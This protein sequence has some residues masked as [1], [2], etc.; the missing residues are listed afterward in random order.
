MALWKSHEKWAERFLEW[1]DLDHSVEDLEALIN[2]P[3]EKDFTLPDHDFNRRTWRDPGNKNAIYDAFGEKGLLAMDLH[4]CLDFLKEKT[5]P[6]KIKSKWKALNAYV[7]DENLP[8][9]YPSV[10]DLARFLA[11][12]TKALDL[13]KEVFKFVL[14]NFRGILSDL[15][16]EH[17]YESEKLRDWENSSFNRIMD[18]LKSVG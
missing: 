3:Q 9:I 1:G 10:M 13:D 6:E 4:Y 12:K 18:G 5:D 15:T 16:A 7:K 11:S 2:F 8:E 17:G 14:V